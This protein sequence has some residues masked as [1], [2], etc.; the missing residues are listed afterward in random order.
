M[1]KVGENKKKVLKMAKIF[2]KKDTPL[3]AFDSYFLKNI[4]YHM[5][6]KYPEEWTKTNEYFMKFLEELHYSLRRGSLPMYYLQNHNM[7]ENPSLHRVDVRNIMT[8]IERLLSD[9]YCI[10]EIMRRPMPPKTAEPHL[11]SFGVLDGQLQVSLEKFYMRMVDIPQYRM[12][13]AK[14]I[15]ETVK[16]RLEAPLRRWLEREH[17]TLDQDWVYTGSAYEG[18]KVCHADEFDI[19]LPFDMREHFTG[20]GRFTQTLGAFADNV[21]STVSL[22]SQTEPESVTDVYDFLDSAEES[23]KFSSKIGG[24][25]VLDSDKVMRMFQSVLKR[26]ANEAEFDDMKI[27]IGKDG[28]SGKVDVYSRTSH[29]LKIDLVPAV[30]NRARYYVAKSDKHD[31]SPGAEAKWRVSYSEEEKRIVSLAGEDK[32]KVLKLAKAFCKEHPP[33]AG[34]ESYYLKTVF[35]HMLDDYPGDWVHTSEYFKKFLSELLSYLNNKTL[36]MYHMQ[37]HNLIENFVESNTESL[38]NIIGRLQSLVKRNDRELIKVL[39]GM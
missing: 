28:P 7:I 2:C 33:L 23:S 14:K 22:F 31:T 9:E 18:L 13:D 21:E 20:I 39:E 24:T 35:L 1:C 3:A 19:M 12:D 27:R 36:P 29:H 15:V 10:I 30:K 25:Y 26:A 34:I 4:F 11:V 38:R 16:E 17:I 8:H 6:D 37:R 32:R 5:L